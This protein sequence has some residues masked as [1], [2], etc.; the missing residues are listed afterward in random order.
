MARFAFDPVPEVAPTGAPG[1]DYQRIPTDPAMFGGAVA[2]A[3]EKL[4]GSVTEAADK[5][6]SY[7]QAKQ[8][9]TNEISASETN[10]WLAKGLTDKFNDFS[11]LQ[12]KAAQDA[13]PKFKQDTEDL[14]QQAI[15]NAGDN[16]QMQ[17]MIAKSSRYLT[18]AYYRYGTNY[19]DQQW[20]TWQTKTSD[21]RANEY[22]N[23]AALAAQHGTWDEVDASLNVSDDEVRKKLEAHGMDADSISAE[24][25]K[26]RGLNVKNI[27]ET[28][29]ANGDPRTAQSVF[30][31]YRDGMDA[32]SVLAV[33]SH[34]KNLNAQLQGK[35][36][37]DEET[38]RSP[39]GGGA[40][41][42]VAG[43][44][45]SF[46]GAIKW[47]EGYDQVP[48]WDVNHW[49]IGYGTK[50]AGPDERLNH[51]QIEQRFQD[52]ITREARIVDAVNPKL[53]PGTR[54]ALI[55]L[56]HNTGDGWTHAGLGD[57][58]RAGDIAGAQQKFLEYANVAGQPNAAI[59]RRRWDEAQWFGQAEAPAGHT[60]PDK[61]DAYN[62]IV[63][64][65]AA[66][67]LRQTAALARMNQIYAV[68]RADNT[69][70]QVL[71]NQR[72][73]DTTAE[74][75]NTGSTANPL[76]ENDFVQARGFAQGR[77][78]YADYKQNLALGADASAAA[79]MSPADRSAL[80]QRYVPQPGVG[81]AEAAKRQ[82]ALN[83]VLTRLDKERQSDPAGYA[84]NRLPDVKAAAQGMAKLEADPKA[85]D[86]AKKA[87]RANYAAVM[88]REQTRIGIPQLDQRLLPQSDIDSMNARFAGAAGNDDPQARTGLV[89]QVQHEAKL[90]GDNWPQVMSQL[91]PQTQPIVRAIAAGAD[92]VAMTRLLAL[93]PKEAKPSVILKQQSETKAGDLNKNTESAMAPFRATMVGRQVDR[94]YSSYYNLATELG[95]LYV[96]DGDDAPTAAT[97]AF[98]A[99]IGNR[100]EFRDTWRIPKSLGLDGDQIQAG[101]LAAR[102]Q[103]ASGAI[104][105]A[106]AIDDMA[107]GQNNRTDSLT[108]FG[109]DG[110][111]VTS[112]KQDGLNLVY[113]DKFVRG[114]DGQPLLLNWDQLA[115]LGGSKEARAEAAG[116]LASQGAQ[117]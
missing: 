47:R 4:G 78:E 73:K 112:P 15:K 67:P 115:K 113:G 75:Y 24:V 58:V 10:T 85:P 21:D 104:A 16:L 70:S 40:A 86:D 94:D 12:G 31:K 50:A 36:D 96:R 41:A 102:N 65:T 22:G 87:A 9:L 90:W 88:E 19:A 61:A 101:T 54:A 32:G 51:D 44:P 62:R 13:L 97:K 93:D 74:A 18:D 83:S 8:G 28:L 52:E 76:N 55:S 107:L 77:S 23:Q 100:Y 27:V 80:E 46:V 17:S 25:K 99:L 69:Q 108:K 34:L 57:R 81:Y 68:E 49:T 66:D 43:I 53:D 38:G 11:Q 111:F 89:G 6:L 5:G 106:P 117:Q 29:S 30:D 45:S 2:G 82:E 95:A 84:V 91:A 35:Q 114:T 79:G 37:A 3:E 72:V 20:R 103:I 116:R 105:A 110:R 63:N 60:L 92:P 14:Y 59:A 71:F 42:P 1:N 109:R 39:R 56:T 7:L 64:R 26:R 48:R 98:N 33:T